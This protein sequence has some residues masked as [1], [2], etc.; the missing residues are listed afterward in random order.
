MEEALKEQGKRQRD[1]A[2]EEARNEANAQKSDKYHKQAR[3]ERAAE[4]AKLLAEK[5]TQDK[6]RY[7]RNKQHALAMEQLLREAEGAS[8]GETTPEGTMVIDERIP[9]KATIMITPK[10]KF[11]IYLNNVSLAGVTDTYEEA[12]KAAQRRAR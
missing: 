7:E 3:A 8:L 4:D 10:L 6:A 12:I 2:R 1:F 11:R 9:R 5:Q